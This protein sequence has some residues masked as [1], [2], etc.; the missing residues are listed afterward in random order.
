MMTYHRDQMVVFVWEKW[1]VSLCIIENSMS[2]I[3]Y[4]RNS[5]NL[6]AGFYLF[7]VSVKRQLTPRGRVEINPRPWE[8][9]KGEEP[10]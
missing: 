4:W 1:P 10:L 2:M 5:K 9:R 7:R 6:G 8:K 3:G